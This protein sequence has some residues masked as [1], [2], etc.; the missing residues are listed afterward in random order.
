VDRYL[1]GKND[2]AEAS[3]NSVRYITKNNFVGLLE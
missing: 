3:K 2:F 1:Y